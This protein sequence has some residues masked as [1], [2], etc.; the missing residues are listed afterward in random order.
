MTYNAKQTPSTIISFHK[1]HAA[2]DTQNTIN[3]ALQMPK[4]QPPRYKRRAVGIHS[5]FG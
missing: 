2:F 5:A 4:K 1:I 3:V